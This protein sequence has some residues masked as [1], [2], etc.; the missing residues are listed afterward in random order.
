[1]SVRIVT[2]ATVLWAA[3]AIPSHAQRAHPVVNVRA[4]SPIGFM[5]E[6]GVTFGELDGGV[7][8]VG[9]EA[10]DGVLDAAHG[11]RREG[12]IADEVSLSA[13]RSV[14]SQD[15]RADIKTRLDRLFAGEQEVGPADVLSF[16]KRRKPRGG[17]INYWLVD[18]TGNYPEK[19]NRGKQLATEY[20]TFVGQYPAYGEY[21]LS[22][23][24][25]SMIERG[26]RA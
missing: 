16:M 20:L 1:M 5:G 10:G 24:V 18:Q 15:Y 21:L 12:A 7:G 9:E 11:A 23:I 3:A 25:H 26:V 13:P 2:L 8:G 17:G 14:K 19:C 6:G 4:G 22:D